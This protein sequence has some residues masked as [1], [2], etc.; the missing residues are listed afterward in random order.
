MFFFSANAELLSDGDEFKQ[1]ALNL[2]KFLSKINVYILK[3]NRPVIKSLLY[4]HLKLVMLIVVF[5]FL[6]LVFILDEEK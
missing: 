3:T 6:K 4:I 1:Q 2:K 5:E